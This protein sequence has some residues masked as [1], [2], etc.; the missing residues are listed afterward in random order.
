MRHVLSGIPD[1]FPETQPDIFQQP[2]TLIRSWDDQ[3]H[4]E[5]SD[6][7]GFR[8]SGWSTCKPANSFPELKN[9]GILTTQKLKSHCE[10]KGTPSHWISLCD[11]A[12][13]ML[14][15][16]NGKTN[17][18]V[19][20][21]SVPKMERLNILWHQSDLLV[22]QAGGKVYNARHQDG[23]QFAWP[24]HCLVYGWIPA[25]CVIKTFTL[26][27]FRQLCKE[28]NIKEGQWSMSPPG[29]RTAKTKSKGDI[30]V[31]HPHILLQPPPDSLTNSVED[32]L[33][34]AFESLQLTAKNIN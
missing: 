16:V 2:W 20:I 10:G 12:S 4:T 1:S 15:Y 8:C 13:W 25:Q 23:V 19:A 3:S 34:N 29:R 26:Q 7:L 17:C 21:V 6:S 33:A 28:R 31:K 27:R 30:F 22:Q 5:Y 14:K 24:R 18:R 9:S 11:N 32:S